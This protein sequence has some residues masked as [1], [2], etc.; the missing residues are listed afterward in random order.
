[1]FPDKHY[2][3]GPGPEVTKYNGM[4]RINKPEDLLELVRC[5]KC[6]ARPV[7]THR[8]LVLFGVRLE[9]VLVIECPYCED[10]RMEE[11]VTIRPEL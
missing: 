2:A 9:D 7:I 11:A 10:S 5:K 3:I 6:K 1:M 4:L 8:P